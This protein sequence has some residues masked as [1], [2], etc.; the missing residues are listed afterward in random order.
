MELLEWLV[1]PVYLE[2][3][4]THQSHLELITLIIHNDEYLFI[5]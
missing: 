3:I 4:T 1:T 5:W 2:L